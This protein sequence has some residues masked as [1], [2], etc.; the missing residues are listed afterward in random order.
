M[1]GLE[2]LGKLTNWAP[3]H[4]KL[5]P[6]GCTCDECKTCWIRIVE[7]EMSKDSIKGM[8][9]AL[10]AQALDMQQFLHLH[11]KFMMCE[12]GEFI[13]DFL[14]SITEEDKKRLIQLSIKKL[15]KEKI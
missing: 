14:N 5:G 6:L 4:I 8:E 2:A 12:F 9:D 10:T 15:E 13:K 11:T 7:E 1:T 3:S